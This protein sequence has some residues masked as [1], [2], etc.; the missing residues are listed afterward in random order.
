METK[1]QVDLVDALIT[2]ELLSLP[3]QLNTKEALFKDTPEKEA[4]LNDKLEIL[5]KHLFAL[6]EARRNYKIAEKETWKAFKKEAQKSKVKDT[7]ISKETP[8][9]QPHILSFF[10]EIQSILDALSQLFNLLLGSNFKTWEKEKGPDEAIRSGKVIAEFI[11]TKTPENKKQLATDLEQ[12]ISGN[13]RWLGYLT[14]VT[15]KTDSNGNLSVISPF[16]FEQKHRTVIPMLF[17][18][19]DGYKEPVLNFMNRATSE[20]I[21]FVINCL[22][23]SFQISAKDLIL[24]KARDKA[25]HLHY[26]WVPAG[27]AEQ[28]NKLQNPDSQ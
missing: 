15:E 7:D 28:L 24:I 25:G 18:H 10:N 16:V 26:Q 11:S 4:E 19:S 12:F 17:T 2:G 20:L 9:L 3:L 6:N 27:A 22:I 14:T 1:P 23:F 8:E 13:G 21:L 5:G